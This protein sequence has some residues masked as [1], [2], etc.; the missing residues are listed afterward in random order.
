M[1][2]GLDAVG[3]SHG[4]VGSRLA[5]GGLVLNAVPSGSRSRR[6]GGG[7]ARASS[8]AVWAGPEIL[9]RLGLELNLWTKLSHIV[10]LEVR[11]DV[12]KTHF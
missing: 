9:G 2:H 11:L 12:L 10:E 8:A 5:L 3:R 7:A 1:F 6:S 4:S